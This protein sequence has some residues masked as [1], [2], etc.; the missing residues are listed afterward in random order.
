MLNKSIT[1][2]M[3]LGII[4]VVIGFAVIILLANTILLRPLYYKSLE[5][6]MTDSI[7]DLAGI[8][9]TDER[10]I[11]VEEVY[12]ISSGKSYDVV[13]RRGDINIFSSSIDI[14]L[15]DNPEDFDNTSMDNPVR[16]LKPKD[17]FQPFN[18]D[19]E[20]KETEENIFIGYSID[21][22]NSNEFI[23]CTTQNNDGF[24]IFL[25]Q[26]VEPIDASINQSNLLLI[27][28]TLIML[29]I[30]ILFALRFSKGFTKPIKEIKGQVGLLSNLDF[31]GQL[32]VKTG[33]ELESLSTD[34]NLLA[35]K[36]RD[37][38]DELKEKNIQLEND[39]IAQRSFISNASHELRTPLSL[40]KGY[41]DELNS[42]YVKD[43]ESQQMYHQIISDESTKLNR[44]LNEMLDLSRL[45]SGRM[46]LNKESIKINDFIHSFLEKYSGFIKEK[47][48]N[49]ELDLCDTCSCL[50]DVMRIEQIMA[51][52][53]SNAAKYSDEK[54]RVIISTKIVG[55][56]VRV[57]V[58]NYGNRIDEESIH[59]IWDGFYK[60]DNA[61]TRN[62]DSY[63]L[64]LS[65]VKAIQIIAKQSYGVVNHDEG[66]EFWFD[67]A[68]L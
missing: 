39:I 17:P 6:S 28:C 4:S 19:M 55:D 47:N 62:D 20:W 59:R 54:K 37:A 7:A 50:H 8:D 60:A 29:V 9:F 56:I 13:V 16:E 25:A 43:S 14:G 66:V 65:I 40:I 23:L 32:E 11:W 10:S 18:E 45:E 63:G 42:G 52:Y 67:A 1:K 26:P 27:V 51:N 64:G 22:K 30:S 48:L 21:P 38:L 15:R 5:N 24:S 68:L 58:F 41:A 2:R 3:F 35:K 46:E 33:D 31:S 12:G 34:I 44:L 57:S 36:L 53:I 49:I 61:R